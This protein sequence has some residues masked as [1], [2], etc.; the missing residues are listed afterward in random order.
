MRAMDIWAPIPLVSVSLKETDSFAPELPT[1][2]CDTSQHLFGWR[3]PHSGPSKDVPMSETRARGPS[4]VSGTES[5][6]RVADILLLFADA[7]RGLG[8]SEVSRRLDLSKAVV[9]RVLRSLE[10]RGL[11]CTGGDGRYRLGPAMLTLGAR[12]LGEQDLRR[13]AL[14]VL[15]RL[16]EATNETTTVSAVVGLRRVYLDQV[17]SHAEIKM[18]VELGRPFPLHAGASGRALLAF[19]SDELRRHVLDAPLRGLTPLTITDPDA[20]ERNLQ[21]TARAGVAMSLG[22]RQHGAGSVAAPVFGPEGVAVGAISV[23]GPVD[24]FA[25]ET[26]RTFAPLV[27]RAAADVSAAL[28]APARKEEAS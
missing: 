6:T 10:S 24:R 18:T 27:R 26:M 13:V 21:E 2:P 25:P 16:Q 28:G 5:A 23:C 7:S 20:L 3:A 12:A 22:E 15:R 19:A 9:H 1:R 4:P 8:V 17:V 14:P 11:V